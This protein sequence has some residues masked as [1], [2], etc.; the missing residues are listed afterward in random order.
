MIISV[1][2]DISLHRIDPGRFSLSQGVR[3]LLASS[4]ITIGNLECV[5]TTVSRRS[6]ALVALKAAP[7]ALSVLNDF[8]CLTLA[9]NHIKDFGS[10]GFSETAKVLQEYGTDFCHDC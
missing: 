1:V 8:N 5:L 10:A 4:E 9:N 7:D 3:D 2:G 6:G